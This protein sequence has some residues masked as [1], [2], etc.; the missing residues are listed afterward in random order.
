MSADH[1]RIC[2]RCEKKR[3]EQIIEHAKNVKEGYGILSKNEYLEA[4]QYSESKEEG[5]PT[6]REDFEIFTDTDG[7][8]YVKYTCYC[9]ECHFIFSFNYEKELLMEEIIKCQQ[10]VKF[11]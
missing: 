11:E 1:W 9:T 5:K 4:I 3:K 7:L 10:D 6:L 8:F 2:P